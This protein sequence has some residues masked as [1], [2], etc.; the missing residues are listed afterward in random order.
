LA[1]YPTLTGKNLGYA[2]GAETEQVHLGEEL[3]RNGYDVSFV[4]YSKDGQ[5]SKEYVNGIEILKTY[6]RERANQ[7]NALHKY[8]IVFSALRKANADVYFHE[9]G[10]IG[11]LPIFCQFSSKRSIFRIPS[12]TT[13]LSR[14]LLEN[15]G[16]KRKF[17]EMLEI[18]QVDTVIAQTDYQKRVLLERFDVESS[19]IKNGLYIPENVTDKPKPPIILWAGSISRIKRPDLFLD[20]AKSIPFAQFEMV[21]GKGE[22]NRLYDE[23]EVAAKKIPNLLFHGFVPCN[24]VN[25]YFRRAS[26]FVNTSNMEGFPNT[27]IHAW[28]NSA[29]VVSLN[30][31]PDKIIQ[32]EKLGFHSGTLKRMKSDI[33]L[34][35]EDENLRACMGK[36]CRNYVEKNHNIQKIVKQYI[37]ILKSFK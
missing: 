14:S 4:T 33:R 15:H 2:G 9:S 21:G 20:I 10:A 30:V 12:D 27:F 25:D 1:S 7:M 16:F 5:N 24:I 34:L 22:P 8:K 6:D 35:L 17:L 36:N 37:S 28:S 13:V 32:N 3:T 29:P 19:V 23:I 31:D 26:I 11:M 18:K